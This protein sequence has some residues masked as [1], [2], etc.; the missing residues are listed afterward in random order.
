[1]NPSS[2]RR[3]V[4]KILALALLLSILLLAAVAFWFDRVAARRFERMGVRVHALHEEMQARNTP[5]PVL[6]GEPEPGNSWTDYQLAFDAL[7][8]FKGDHRRITGYVDS[9]AAADHDA[10][11]AALKAHLDVFEHLRRGARRTTGA[12]PG[13]WEDG[14]Q[15]AMPPLYQ[16]QVL[17]QAA[18]CRAKFLSEEGKHREAAELLLDVAQFSRDIRQ[19]QI[20]LTD[21]IGQAIHVIAMSE[22]RTL[23][24]G[25]G[26]RVADFQEIDRELEILDRNDP[27]FGPSL[28]NE[29]VCL[30]FDLMHGQGLRDPQFRSKAWES[31]RYAFSSRIM[32]ADALERFDADMAEASGAAGKSWSQACAIYGQLEGRLQ[33]EKNPIVHF[34]EGG[35]MVSDRHYRLGVAFTRLL[36]AASHYRAS[37][38]ILQPEDPFGGRL[39]HSEKDGRLKVWSVG[40]DGVDDGGDGGGWTRWTRPAG[41]AKDIVLEVPR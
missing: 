39:L 11:A 38:E 23:V 12:F 41:G 3:T 6:R 18:A 26:L 25:E 17:A 5:R 21:M 22:L 40:P 15:M 34:F 10:V 14:T 28:K 31:W 33:V 2:P 16:C 35:L 24:Q 1:M 36:R 19:N 27:P 9:G 20:L 30:G 32:E 4:R 7:G 8:T 13:R 37:G 29:V